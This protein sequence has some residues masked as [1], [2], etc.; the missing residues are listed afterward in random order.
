M[1]EQK[2]TSKTTRLKYSTVPATTKLT[3]SAG[4]NISLE[5]AALYK[6]E[7]NEATRTRRSRANYKTTSQISINDRGRLANAKSVTE[8]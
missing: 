6:Q 7:K 8:G 4:T 3:I 1:F 5:M 2:R